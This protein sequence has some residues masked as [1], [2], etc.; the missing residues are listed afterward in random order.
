MIDAAT[1]PAAART[2]PHRLAEAAEMAAAEP[3]VPAISPIVL[4][5]A[6]RMIEISL[7][8]LIGMLIYVGYVVPQDGVEWQYF[9]AIEMS[10]ILC[11]IANA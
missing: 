8:A 10:N 1:G 7:V 9:A 11:T 4:A 5:G 6:V 3:V 2:A